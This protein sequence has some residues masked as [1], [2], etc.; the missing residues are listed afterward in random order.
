M[1]PDRSD[2]TGNI[3]S[4]C[5]GKQQLGHFFFVQLPAEIP[6][7]ERNRAAAGGCKLA[8]M[9]LGVVFFRE[10][11]DIGKAAVRIHGDLVIFCGNPGGQGFGRQGFF[12]CAEPHGKAEICIFPVFFIRIEKV[13][14][15][16]C[17][18]R[19][20]ASAQK[21]FLIRLSGKWFK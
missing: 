17:T 20:P 2:E 14:I 15:R 8:R 1:T 19:D 3:R 7:R 6:F 21:P 11:F 10:R 9:T 18:G 5:L 13:G 16:V 4:L 12:F